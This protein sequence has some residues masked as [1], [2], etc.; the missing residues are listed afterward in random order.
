[1]VYTYSWGDLLADFAFKMRSMMFREWLSGRRSVT[2]ICKEYRLSRKCFY[3]FRKRFERSGFEG[4]RDKI[5]RPPVMPHALS[6]EKK[7]AIMDCIY[8]T[9]VRGPRHIAMVLRQKG[10]CMSEGAIWN[11]LAQ[12]GLNTRRRRRRWAESQGK[13]TLTEKEKLCIAARRG[14]IQSSSAGELISVDS[15][16]ASVKSLGRVWQFTACDT[17]SSYGWAKVYREK[18]SD[19][20][21]D[22]FINHILKNTPQFKIKRV[23]TDRGT[24]FYNW[25]QNLLVP[26]Y[27]TYQLNKLGVIHSLTKVQ[28]PWTNG[29]VERLNQTIWQEFYLSRLSKPF[30]SLDELNDELQRFMR[31]YNFKRIHSGYKLKAGGFRFPA[32]AFFDI[33]ERAR[34]VEINY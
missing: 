2:D 23:L 20:A 26:H 6:L 3:K 16:T 28:H 32:H 7:L 4:L 25:H 15:F 12:E 14:H 21:V 10:I 13:P 30:T 9:P 33:H 18:T 8:D 1:M 11:F 19:N 22:F 34:T 24:E 31:D 27:F 5:R 17:Y 29:Y